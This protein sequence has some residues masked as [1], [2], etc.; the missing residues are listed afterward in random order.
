MQVCKGAIGMLI[1]LHIKY[2]DGIDI[3]TFK[4]I[5]K[6]YTFCKLKGNYDNRSTRNWTEAIHLLWTIIQAS[7]GCP[8]FQLT[9]LW[10][11]S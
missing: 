11:S 8:L 4:N 7:Q 10:M 1:R 6:I 9:K 5:F 3:V 2:T